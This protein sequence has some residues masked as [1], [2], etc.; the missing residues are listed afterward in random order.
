MPLPNLTTRPYKGTIVVTNIIDQTAKPIPNTYTASNTL[1]ALIMDN[2][3]NFCGYTPL[4]TDPNTKYMS[5]TIN[6]YLNTSTATGLYLV[7]YD[8]TNNVFPYSALQSFN[9]VNGMKASGLFVC[10][11]NF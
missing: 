3:N 4:V 8:T 1:M 10:K 9:F 5:A 6:V 7:V 2:T 11:K